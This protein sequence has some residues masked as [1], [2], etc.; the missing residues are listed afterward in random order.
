MTVVI[1]AAGYPFEIAGMLLDKHSG[2]HQGRVGAC[3]YQYLMRET[4][5]LVNVGPV[6]LGPTGVQGFPL[7]P[8]CGET[9][10]PQA[11]PVEIDHFRE[12]SP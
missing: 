8:V 2:G 11:S 9:R 10:S 1:F 3:I 12:V 4:V 5:R 6:R 7:C